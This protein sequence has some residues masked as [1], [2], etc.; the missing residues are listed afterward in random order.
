MSVCQEVRDQVV[1]WEGAV[2]PESAPS[3]GSFTGPASHEQA[4]SFA[5]G[6]S[7]VV[8]PQLSKEATTTS[9][10]ADFAQFRAERAADVLDRKSVV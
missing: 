8:E 2:E 9:A 6:R 10:A 5:S 3:F 7:A 1:V 4:R